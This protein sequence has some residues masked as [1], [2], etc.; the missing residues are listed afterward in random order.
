M[1]VV[2]SIYNSVQGVAY[3]SLQNHINI[4]LRFTDVQYPHFSAGIDEW[5]ACLT[6]LVFCKFKI[7]IFVFSYTL[8]QHYTSNSIASLMQQANLP[9]MYIVYE[10][11]I[12]SQAI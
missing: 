12:I 8:M 7:L 4:S 6:S 9:G 10:R 5:P 1:H 11:R 2:S 3:F